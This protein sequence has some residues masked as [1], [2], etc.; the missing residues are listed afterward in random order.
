MAS[1][2]NLKDKLHYS[3]NVYYCNIC[4]IYCA[5]PL[6]LQSHFLGNKHKAV[7]EALK[8]HGVIKTLK[9]SREAAKPSESL[10]D[11]IKTEPEKYLG[12]T[13]EEQLNSCKDTE[14]A[15]GLEYI[16][17][18]RSKDNPIYECSLCIS[19]AGLTNMFM[20]VLGVK[21]RLTY[22]RKHH[23]ELADVKGRGTILNRRLKELA[24][25]VERKDGR[26]RIK[27]T[28]DIPILKD[29]IYSVQFKD[30]LITWFAEDDAGGGKKK[31]PKSTAESTKDK[32]DSN[33]S[34]DKE[35]EQSAM[36]QQNAEL[37]EVSDSEELSSNEDLL[38]YL[39][40]FEI[41]DEEDAAFVLRVTQKLTTA[42]VTYR[43]KP[44][45]KNSNEGQ[46]YGY[47]GGQ[48]EQRTSAGAAGRDMDFSEWELPVEQSFENTGTNPDVKT[49]VKRKASE[50]NTPSK[51]VKTQKLG[52]FK[53]TFQEVPN[54]PD[55]DAE[56][57]VAAQ[58]QGA[59][60]R[61]AEGPSAASRDLQGPAQGKDIPSS[62]QKQAN[63]PVPSPSL[64]S[65][66]E[67]QV[68][69]K[70]F[71]SIRNM[72]AD[73]VAATLQKIAE[74]NPTFSGMDVQNVIKIL[75]Q[76]GNLKPKNTASK[77]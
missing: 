20:H 18:Y 50:T 7:E 8:T 51:D 39:K 64:P 12:K 66:S 27:S 60:P 61:D 10:P 77:S 43:Y 40:S 48:S 17:E 65:E 62:V 49:S 73:E 6:N 59:A 32:C 16:M 23:P 67:S 46:P 41:V 19:Q 13:L 70:F 75:T 4:K 74:S 29:D 45:K 68:I 34:E 22:L 47:M 3:T 2:E 52:T 28:M 55:C 58:E 15:I 56:E 53:N 54:E 14:P 44:K 30:S 36:Q 72:D 24:A 69:A 31:D 11:Y 35:A 76:S 37:L 5:S 26:K 9:D 21:H 42:L 38:K 1:E 57:P 33:K 63:V 25:L 71:S